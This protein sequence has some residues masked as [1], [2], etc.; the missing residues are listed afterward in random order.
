MGYSDIMEAEQLAEWAKIRDAVVFGPYGSARL[1]HLY[2]LWT[3]GITQP[4]DLDSVSCDMMW[5]SS[6]VLRDGQT[7]SALRE[8]GVNLSGEG[9]L[10][11]ARRSGWAAKGHPAL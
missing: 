11:A 5:L 9:F 10:A 4:V 8:C 2:E 6:A 1:H 7:M 3:A